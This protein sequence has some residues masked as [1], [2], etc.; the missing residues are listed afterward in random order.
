[1]DISGNEIFKYIKSVFSKRLEAETVELT[2]TEGFKRAVL[3]TYASLILPVFINIIDN[4]LF[5]IKNKKDDRKIRFHLIDED[6]CVSDNG[7]GIKPQYRSL[8]FE[9][10]YTLKPGGRGLGL[11]ISKQVLNGEGFDIEIAD[12]CF[13][14]GAGFKILKKD[15][16]NE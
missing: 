12:S 10:G 8:I 7:P 14:Q 16:K 3:H 1:V 11:Y 5:W 6:M 13:D 9:R 2:Q 15:L 4:A